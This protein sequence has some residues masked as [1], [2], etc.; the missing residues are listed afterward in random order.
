MNVRLFTIA[1]VAG[2]IAGLSA[3]AVAHDAGRDVEIRIAPVHVPYYGLHRYERD[4]RYRDRYD[5]YHYLHGKHHFKVHKRHRRAHERWHHHNDH[6]WDRWYYRDHA[7][8]HRRLASG[9]RDH[10]HRRYRH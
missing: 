5:R 6:R 7:D 3:P 9:R 4:Y 1:T 8:L 2:L 10:N